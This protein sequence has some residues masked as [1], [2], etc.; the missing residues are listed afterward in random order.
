MAK[1]M[2]PSQTVA[3]FAATLAVCYVGTAIMWAWPDSANWVLGATVVLVTIFLFFVY[4]AA[5]KADPPH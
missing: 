5:R 4:R 2:T 1:T 3:G